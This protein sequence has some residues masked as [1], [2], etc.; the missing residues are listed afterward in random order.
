MFLFKTSGRTLCSVIGN[1]KHAF[2]GKPQEWQRGE[3]VL[4]SKN[5][6][7]CGPSERQIQFAMRLDSIRPILPGEANRYWPGT[8]GRWRY[9]VECCDTAALRNPFNLTEAL[10]EE[11][12]V[13]SS[14]MTFKRLTFAHEQDVRAF[15]NIRDPG[16][17]S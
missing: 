10:G 12:E 7:D 3:L 17:L 15:L 6:V 4:V 14:V 11:A 8:E 13:Y 5:K 16:V 1:Q 9:L 2:R